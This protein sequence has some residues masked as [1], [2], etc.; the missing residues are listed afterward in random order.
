MLSFIS[1]IFFIIYIQCTW[2]Y[3]QPYLYNV[4]INSAVT[5]I[6]FILEVWQKILIALYPSTH[7][8]QESIFFYNGSQFYF[9][10]FFNDEWYLSLLCLTLQLLLLHLWVKI[11][12]L[13]TTN[14][15]L[16]YLHNCQIHKPCLL[17]SWLTVYST[18]SLC[19][20]W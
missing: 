11:T 5:V 15:A 12:F 3:C 8:H 18:W 20:D 9:I 1:P 13:I 2:K 17:P 14:T 4:N 6:I 19:R 16:N 10:Y 7:F